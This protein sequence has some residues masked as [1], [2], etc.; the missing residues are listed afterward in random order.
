EKL[1]AG[2][3]GWKWMLKIPPV[4]KLTDWLMLPMAWMKATCVPSGALGLPAVKPLP[5]PATPA[6]P[7]NVQGVPDGSYWNAPVPTAG[8]SKPASPTVGAICAPM[9]NE[10]EVAAAR[11]PSLADSV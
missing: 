3:A 9:V 4:A 11:L 7:V 10:L 5:L 6:P 8:A 2:R 1:E